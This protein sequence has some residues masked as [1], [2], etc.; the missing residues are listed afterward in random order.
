MSRVIKFFFRL[1]TW[2]ICIVIVLTNPSCQRTR[3]NQ[4]K[5]FYKLHCFPLLWFLHLS[6]NYWSNLFRML[7][8]KYNQSMTPIC[9]H[10]LPY[11]MMLSVHIHHQNHELLNNGCTCFFF[12]PWHRT[13]SKVSLIVTTS[14]VRILLLHKRFWSVHWFSP[15]VLASEASWSCNKILDS[16]LNMWRR[17]CNNNF[18]VTNRSW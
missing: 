1:G 2:W 8:A 17:R 13:I 6:Y 7:Y 4:C 14:A 3:T 10:K 11:C 5:L 12:G 9:C 15:P 18:V 16:I